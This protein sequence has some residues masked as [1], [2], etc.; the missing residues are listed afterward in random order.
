MMSITS[1]ALIASAKGITLLS[2][3]PPAAISNAT[4]SASQKEPQPPCQ[5]NFTVAFAVDSSRAGLSGLEQPP[6]EKTVEES[7][8]DGADPST[9]I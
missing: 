1:I 7:G 8:I 9:I 3:L 2:S 4:A 5:S 6:F